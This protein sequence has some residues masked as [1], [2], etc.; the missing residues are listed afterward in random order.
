MDEQYQDYETDIASQVRDL[1]EKNKLIKERII[2]LSQN[3][4][5]ERSKN[6]QEI[7][8]MKKS[9]ALLKEENIKIKEMMQRMVEQVDKLARREELM[10]L[11]RQ[12]DL[13]RSG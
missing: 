1:E 6:F 8:E 3:F 5:D 10:I 9:L 7:Q 11:Q 2:L 13:F 12:F 4:I